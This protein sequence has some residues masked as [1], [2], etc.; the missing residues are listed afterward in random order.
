[1]SKVAVSP[2][3]LQWASERSS[4]GRAELEDRF[5]K[6]ARWLTGE[7][8]PTLNQLEQFSKAT[9]TPLGFLFLK[10]PPVERLNIPYYRTLSDTTVQSPSTELLDT[11]HTMQ[12]RQAW[13]RDYLV[14][15]GREQVS[16]VNCAKPSED[17]KKVA[18]RVR[19]LLKLEQNWATQQRTWSDALRTLCDAMGTAGIVVVVN[20]VVGNNTH[21][22]LDVEEFRGFVLVDDYAPLVFVNGADSKSA[23]MFTFAH[24]LAHVAFGSSAAF[25]LRQMQPANNAT[26]QA[27]NRVAAE[28]LV[29]EAILRQ[30]WNANEADPYE[31]VARAFK[32]SQI[33]AAR[34]LL[35]LKLIT[36]EIFFDFYQRYINQERK[37]RATTESGGNFHATSPQRVGMRFAVEL[38]R[39]LKEGRVLHTEAY[40]LTGLSGKSFGELARRAQEGGLD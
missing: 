37:Q 16:L 19:E 23:Q 20:G 15:E 26:E 11:L 39:A 18:D 24:E 33:V 36:R 35:D 6:L 40:R 30:M 21:R 9:A 1:M 2:E 10:A 38:V 7:D 28:F 25:D 14:E 17:T 29:P 5:P 13:L 27:C 8:A 34:R 4:K 3:L 32:V 12:R 31:M 22:P